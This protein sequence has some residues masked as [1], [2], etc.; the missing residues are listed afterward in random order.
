MARVACMV[1]LKNE[2]TMTPRFLSYHAALFGIENV[3]VF[4]NGSTDPDV[5]SELDRFEARGGHV[6]RRFNTT[7]D[8]YRKGTVLGDLIKRLDREM[9]YDFYVPLDCDEFVV[10]RTPDGYTADAAAI[11]AYLDGL[12][13]DRRILH[14]TL[15]LSN[16]LGEPDMFRP[17]EYSKTVWPREVFLHMDHGYHTGVGRNDT[18]P[19][20]ECELVYA[21]FH[22]RPY[23][24]VVE[25]AKQKLRGVNLPDAEIEDHASLREFRGI[26]WHMVH[27]IV[28]GPEAYYSQF[29][30][31][32][33]TV[34]FP[35]IAERFA[36]I[37]IEVPFGGFRLPPPP[38][39]A[40]PPL[41]LIDEAS[42]V[43]I[44][45]WALDREPPHGPL[46]LRFLVDGLLVWEG[47]CDQSRPDVRNAG[48]P[49]D[50]VGFNFPLPSASS[51]IGNHVL[52]VQTASGAS[53]RMLVD[54]QARGELT[55][56]PASADPQAIDVGGASDLTQGPGDGEANTIYSHIDSF[57]NG[58]V[59]G[60]VL[61]AVT[62][63][64]GRRLLGQCI[65]VVAHD[66]LVVAQTIANIPRPDVAEALQGE[67]RCGFKIE[68]PRP[69]LA[70]N[71]S[72][73]FRLFVMPEQR[74]LTGSPCVLAPDFAA[75]H[76]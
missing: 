21:H 60:W 57:R 55:L 6:D 64:G 40:L 73:A 67:D 61:R 42:T 19:Y 32:P 7:E 76:A 23:E 35:G 24:E 31:A 29:R 54:G 48:H 28:D 56:A 71:R 13:G 59:Q 75:S 47:L 11:H 38:A 4:D 15:N 72:A 39:A 12:R 52:T 18:S 41:L 49:T 68:V 26:G 25:F 10:L 34:R 2:R 5:L 27:Y 51:A 58:V 45:G 3:Y 50:R 46:F 20:F 44:R 17:A 9:D 33:V 70:P 66:G 30:D 62:T 65:V 1:M 36:E 53:M 37:G 74:E 43:R 14:V 22:Y 16:L 63:L 69:A 8:F